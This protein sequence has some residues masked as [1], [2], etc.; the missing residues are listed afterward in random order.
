VF[1]AGWKAYDLSACHSLAAMSSMSYEWLSGCDRETLQ[2]LPSAVLADHTQRYLFRDSTSPVS[3][4][5]HAHETPDFETCW[6]PYF[7]AVRAHTKL[8][9][10][11]EQR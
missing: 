4:N 2:N 8:K 1:S 3:C 5:L 11:A 7:K 6:K 9:T 10:Y